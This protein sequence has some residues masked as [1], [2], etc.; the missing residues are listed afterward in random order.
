MLVS[1]TELRLAVEHANF[2]LAICVFNWNGKL[3]DELVLAA[4]YSVLIK[5]DSEFD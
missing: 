2:D 4:H 1:G 5:I 3:L